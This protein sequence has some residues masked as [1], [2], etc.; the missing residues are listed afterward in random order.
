MRERGEGEG[1]EGE[2]VGES[3]GER[4]VMGRRKEKEKKEEGGVQEEEKGER[5]FVRLFFCY[6]VFHAAKTEQREDKCTS[7]VDVVKRAQEKG[8]MI[9]WHTAPLESDRLV[10]NFH[11][12]V[13]R[14][15]QVLLFGGWR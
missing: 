14:H 4:G 1:R 3:G 6:N 11:D 13:R 5:L 12:E 9:V 8:N 10:D 7:C 15:S 2:R